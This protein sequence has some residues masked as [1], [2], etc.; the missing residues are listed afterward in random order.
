[1]QVRV[2]VRGRSGAAFA[3][4]PAGVPAHVVLFLPDRHAL[5]DLVNDVAAGE[6]RLVAMRCAHSPP[7]RRLADRKLADAVQARG[8]PHAK[9]RDRLGEDALTFAN[10]ERLEGLVLQAPYAHALV[11]IAHPAFERRVSAAGRIGE[12][13]AQRLWVD[14]RVGEAEHGVC[15]GRPHPPA[16]GGMNTTAS[17]SASGVDHSLNSAFIATRSTSGASVNG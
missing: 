17:P 3:I 12:L 6:K 16:T 5:L 13:R 2:S 14:G 4:H 1:M 9:A 15:G 10:G 11:G 7:T 8:V